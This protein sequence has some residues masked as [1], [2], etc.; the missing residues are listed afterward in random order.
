M[1]KKLKTIFS[2]API[3]TSSNGNSDSFIEHELDTASSNAEINRSIGS[4]K[5]QVVQI[6]PDSLPEA[7]GS[8]KTHSLVNK[9]ENLNDVAIYRN[10]LSKSSQ[11]QCIDTAFSCEVKVPAFERAGSDCWRQGVARGTSS[12]G[13]VEDFIGHLTTFMNGCTVFREQEI[14]KQ[15]SVYEIR[16]HNGH[17]LVLL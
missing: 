14:K 12:Q 11:V 8:S 6:Q 13:P 3:L 15:G 17:C 1:L 4:K 2:R 16:N 10:D 5:S 7:K 9:K